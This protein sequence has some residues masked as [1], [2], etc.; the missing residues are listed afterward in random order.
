MAH[1]S[2]PEPDIVADNNKSDS[3]D[4]N[5]KKEVP[6]KKKTVKVDQN[7]NKKEEVDE[8]EDKKSKS[9]EK[10]NPV[11]EQWMKNLEMLDLKS[12]DEMISP[13]Q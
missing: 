12:L 8:S 2:R 3:K 10:E 9:I 6:G 5:Q 1:I 11:T 4:K 13:N 7:E